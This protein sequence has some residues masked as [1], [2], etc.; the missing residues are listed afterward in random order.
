MVRGPAN[1]TTANVRAARDADSAAV[2]AKR[3]RTKTRMAETSAEESERIGPDCDGDSRHYA[4]PSMRI[5]NR[6]T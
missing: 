4:W 3:R 6:C 1:G 2:A 5:A